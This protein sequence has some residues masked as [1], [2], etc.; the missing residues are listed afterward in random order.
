MDPF[1]MTIT[2][3][4]TGH[5]VLNNTPSSFRVHLGR[6]IHLNG[7]WEVGLAEIHIPSTLYTTKK[8]SIR[9]GDSKV[10]EMIVK[11]DGADPA[12]SL[13]HVECSIIADQHLDHQHH[14]YLRTI[15]V[16]GAAYVENSVKTHSFG[17]I[18]YYPLASRTLSDIEINIITEKGVTASFAGGTLTLLLHFRERRHSEYGE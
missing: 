6:S 3:D 9:G 14:K 5:Y 13:L 4:S 17:Q 2:S 15:N 8:T 1:Y 11:T 7:A 12:V 16:K 18:F 10:P